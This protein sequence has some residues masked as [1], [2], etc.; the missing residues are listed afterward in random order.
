MV[1][2]RRGAIAMAVV[3]RRSGRRRVRRTF[4]LLLFHVIMS[5][6]R[7]MAMGMEMRRGFFI[8]LFE[9]RLCICIC[10]CFTLFG[11]GFTGKSGSGGL[12]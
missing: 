7:I 3:G 1:V 12:R 9:H 2:V 4:L 11:G 10:G 5:I 6:V 8:L